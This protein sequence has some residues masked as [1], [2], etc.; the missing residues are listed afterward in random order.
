MEICL[1]QT[2]KAKQIVKQIVKIHLQK[3]ADRKI[4]S[5]GLKVGTP[6]PIFGG[7][8]YSDSGQIKVR[9]ILL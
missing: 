5:V 9:L 7:N 8:Y 2:G 4:K 3:N 6:D 1:D